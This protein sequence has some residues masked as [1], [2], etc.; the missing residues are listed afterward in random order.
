MLNKFPEELESL[1]RDIQ[2]EN[3][4][5]YLRG[6]D[7]ARLYRD[8]L[9]WSPNKKHWTLAYTIF[10]ATMGNDVGHLA[11]GSK[12]RNAQL[13]HSIVNVQVGCGQS[14]WA[15]WISETCFVFGAQLYIPKTKTSLTPI[16]AI[17]IYKGHSVYY[18]SNYLKIDMLSTNFELPQHFTSFDSMSLEAA[19]VASS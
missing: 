7:P 1:L 5:G 11:W 15:R 4:P 19:I 2:I 16:V 13:F 6:S 17:D 8:E 9:V 18:K 14:P 10:E 12:N 3:L